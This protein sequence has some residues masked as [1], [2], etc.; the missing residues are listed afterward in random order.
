ML[1][2]SSNAAAAGEGFLDTPLGEQLPEMLAKLTMAKE[3][4]VKS[5]AQSAMTIFGAVA[6]EHLKEVHYLSPML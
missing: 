6:R 3:G 5:A 1:A 2:L 4:N